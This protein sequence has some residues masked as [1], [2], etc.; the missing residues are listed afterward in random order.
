[1]SAQI[2]VRRAA[3]RDIDIIAG[4][5]QAMAMETEE[6]QLDFDTIHEGVRALMDKPS[7]GYYIVAEIDGY[8]AGTCM[9]TFE[10]SDWRNGLFLWIQSVYVHPDFRRRGVFRA[11][12]DFVLSEKENNVS[13]C[14]LRLYVEKNNTA[15]ISTYRDL[16]MK[17]TSYRL[18]EITD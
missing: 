16:G 2:H 3:A 6:K 5:N 13:V 8:V 12:Y 18:F 15:A 11:M 17:E 1:M 14:G 10:W 4:Y 9:I 7:L